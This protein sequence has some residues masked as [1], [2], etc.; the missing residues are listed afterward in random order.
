MI[1]E[2]ANKV[3]WNGC[4]R[5]IPR[6]PAQIA[7]ILHAGPQSLVVDADVV[8]AV[9]GFVFGLPQA[10]VAGGVAAAPGLIDRAVFALF[11]TTDKILTAQTT[12]DAPAAPVAAA[13]LGFHCGGAGA[14]LSLFL[15][16]FPQIAVDDRDMMVAQIDLCCRIRIADL[17]VGQIVRCAAFLLAEITDVFFVLQNPVDDGG[18]PDTALLWRNLLCGQF[19][20]NCARTFVCVGVLFKNKAHDSGFRLID[21]ERAV[22]YAVTEQI[23]SEDDALFHASGLSP[24][25]ALGCLA[26]F[27]L[28]DACHQCKPKLPVGVSGINVIKGKKHADSE[29][30]QLSGVGEGIDGISGKAADL[31]RKD[32]IHFAASGGF[33]HGVKSGTLLG[34]GSADALIIIDMGELPVFL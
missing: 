16:A 25:D 15:C 3:D 30:F 7:D 20:C 29:I 17:L 24:L 12:L 2:N 22:L 23:S 33:D 13:V 19:H 27:L 4:V 11:G 21:R 32:Q 18:R 9:C 26:A 34:L 5:E 6:N 1:R 14:E 8:A 31:L 10:S 28:C